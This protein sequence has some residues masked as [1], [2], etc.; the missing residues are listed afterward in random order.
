MS[1]NKKDIHQ[2][3]HDVEKDWEWQVKDMSDE[4]LMED[5]SYWMK[6]YGRDHIVPLSIFSSNQSSN[7]L[8]GNEDDYDSEVHTL[9]LE[10][11]QLR[12]YGE[13]YYDDRL[14]L[15]SVKKPLVKENLMGEIDA[16]KV[17]LAFSLFVLSRTDD[18][19]LVQSLREFKELFQSQ[20][21]SVANNNVMKSNP[22]DEITKM[23]KKMEVDREVEMAT[24]RSVDDLSG[25]LRNLQLDVNSWK[26]YLR[27]IGAS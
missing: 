7:F 21:K 2:I 22:N 10:F 23:S 20:L 8:Y 15:K 25:V 26:K 11:E 24:E 4:E 13:I 5:R 1:V 9:A 19:V 27:D 14:K 16:E 18:N 3:L 12:R 6:R 17:T